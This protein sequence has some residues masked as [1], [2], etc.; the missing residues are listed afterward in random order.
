MSKKKIII[1]IKKKKY[2][3]K[4]SRK[5][6][7]KVRKYKKS[8]KKNVKVR[9]YK[10]SVKTMSGRGKRDQRKKMLECTCG[11]I[12][13][14]SYKDS[15]DA[16]VSKTNEWKEY[17]DK[18]LYK[19]YKKLWEIPDHESDNIITPD[20]WRAY[21]YYFLVKRNLKT[22]NDDFK[23]FFK[24][25]M[26]LPVTE[27]SEQMGARKKERYLQSFKSIMSPGCKLDDSVKYLAKNLIKFIKK[28]EDNWGFGNY[29]IAKTHKPSLGKT[30]WGKTPT[31]VKK[32]EKLIEGFGNDYKYIFDHTLPPNYFKKVIENSTTST[33]KELF[34]QNDIRRVLAFCDRIKPIKFKKDLINHWKQLIEQ[35]TSLC[36]GPK[37]KLQGVFHGSGACSGEITQFYTGD[38]EQSGDVQGIYTTNVLGQTVEIYGCLDRIIDDGQCW[39]RTT[40]NNRIWIIIGIVN[41]E[42]KHIR[43]DRHKERMTNCFRE[44]INEVWWSDFIG[45]NANSLDILPLYFAEICRSLYA[46]FITVSENINSVGKLI[47]NLYK[48]SEEHNN[49]ANIT[50]LIKKRLCNN[51]T[52]YIQ[53]LIKNPNILD[54]MP[55][56]SQKILQNF[57][58]SKKCH[59]YI[60]WCSSRF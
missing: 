31:I 58:K 7:V 26:R 60:G 50:N 14:K 57:I 39:K 51:T 45:E 24:S 56:H 29:S 55:G 46:P 32:L 15:R 17:M 28:K 37:L 35:K 2:N 19:M 9:Q 42:G 48:L 49:R 3:P 1:K 53:T 11:I 6:N 16:F 36:F 59:D 10:K 44:G 25:H 33:E 12:D 20:K 52:S 5:K 40:D 13:Q 23:T 34:K 21:F 41:T 4:I 8:R 47:M 54:D 38:D 30:I 18:E 43:S 27:Q 22:D